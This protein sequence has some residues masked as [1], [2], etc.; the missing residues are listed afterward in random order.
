M[1]NA[2]AFGLVELAP[3][4]SRIMLPPS[5][6]RPRPRRASQALLVLARSGSWSSARK[7]ESPALRLKEKT[8]GSV[9][10]EMLPLTQPLAGSGL[11]STVLLLGSTSGVGVPLCTR[12]CRW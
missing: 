4:P 10:A 12:R 1:K 2:S 7:T 3:L 8:S 6:K 5:P 9:V 11:A